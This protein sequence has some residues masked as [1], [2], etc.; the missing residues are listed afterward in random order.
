ALAGWFGCDPARQFAMEPAFHPAADATRYL[1]GT[2]N[3]L[4]L[5]PLLGSLPVILKAGVPAI[6]RKSL[7]LTDYLRSQI[8][9]RLA[10]FGVTVVT[11]REDHRRGGHVTLAHAEADRLSRAL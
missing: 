4:S 2:P 3:I 6:R 1:M 8:E 5:A 10:R 7:A 9:T 11:P